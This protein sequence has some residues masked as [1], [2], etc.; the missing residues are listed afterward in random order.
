[1]A[2]RRSSAMSAFLTQ[3]AG[4]F[5]RLP[6]ELLAADPPAPRKTRASKARR[7]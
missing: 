2:W 7:T 1:M 5:K 6:R 4:E 3:L